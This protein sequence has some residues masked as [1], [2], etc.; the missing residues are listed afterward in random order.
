MAAATSLLVPEKH[1]TRIAGLNQTMQGLLSIIS[2]PLGALAV[3]FLPMYGVMGI[4]IFTF[5]FAILPLL[6]LAIPE[7]TRAPTQK[8][9]YLSDLK[10]GFRYVWN[11]RGLFLLLCLAALLNGIAQPM[12]SLLPLLIKEHFGRGAL[13]LGWAESAW[14]I[15]VVLGGLFLSA[16]GGFRKKIHT[17]LLGVV[18]MGLGFGLL[19]LLPPTWFYP[20]LG[21]FLLAGLMTVSYTHLTLPTRA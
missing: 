17:I 8:L 11:W 13:E 15:G 10:A 20:A 19:G 9:T 2:P 18:G 14:G 5:F 1:L 21:L 6:F 3:S 4:D 12:G 7:P 16:W